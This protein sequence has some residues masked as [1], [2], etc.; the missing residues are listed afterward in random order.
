MT[1]RFH[2]VNICSGNVPALEDFYRKLFDLQDADRGRSQIR[3][4]GY[5]GDVA[6]LTD[7]H[8]EMHLATRDLG[9]A[10]RTGQSLNPLERGHLAFRTDDLTEIK[11][12]LRELNIPFADFGAWAMKGWE[13]IFLYDPEGNI[14]EVHQV[15]DSP[16]AE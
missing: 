15:R 14:V 9:V 2:H 6:F 13:Q 10:F 8:T 16:E 4:Q 12:R 3:T 1:T 5:A 7:G 11:R